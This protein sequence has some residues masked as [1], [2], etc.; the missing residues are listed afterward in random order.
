MDAKAQIAR[1]TVLGTQAHNAGR[2]RVVGWD[3]E[4]MALIAGRKNFETPK[5]EASS[6]EIMK[7]WL[8]AWDAARV[9][10]MLEQ[11]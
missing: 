9:A 3:G 1:A 4:L 7:A 11:A 8:R 10:S 6:A 5:G 2:D